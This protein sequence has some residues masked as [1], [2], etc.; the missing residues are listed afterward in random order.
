VSPDLRVTGETL[1]GRYWLE[2]ELGRG[3]TATVYLA[4]DLKHKRRVAL[5]ILNP[6][7]AA[8]V[9][10]R[11]LREIEIVAQLNHPNVLALYDSGQSDSLL[12]YVMPFVEGESLRDQ[13]VRRGRLPVAEAL[14]LT[15]EIADGLR[16][17]HRLG[18]VHR[19]IKPENILL[20]EGHAVIADFGIA[21]ALSVAGGDRLTESG[22]GV[23]TPAYMSPEQARGQGEVTPRSDVYSLGCV[24]YEMLAGEPPFSGPSPETVLAQKSAGRVPSLRRISGVFPQAIDDTLNRALASDPGERFESAPEFAEALSRA[25]DRRMVA[26]RRWRGWAAVA[27]VVGAAVIVA[28]GV[29]RDGNATGGKPPPGLS[30][31]GAKVG[32]LP[33]EFLGTPVDSADRQG[34]IVQ[35]LLAAELT[36]FRGLAVIDPLS[37][38]SRFQGPAQPSDP[39]L[40]VRD[41]GLEYVVRIT[42]TP[43]APGVRVSYALT[44]TRQG[45]VISAG[46]F[47]ATGEPDLTNRIRSA[48]ESLYA[49]LD[50]V[51]G[52]LSK[53]VDLDPFLART[54]KADAV[55]AFL[56][57][58][59]YSYRAIPGGRAHFERA[60]QLDPD[61][62]APRVWLVS[63][64]IEAGD[65]AGAGQHLRELHARA[66]GAT[67][68]EQALIGWA[69]G[70]VRGDLEATVRHLQV[71]LGYSP[72]NN[73]LLYSL[74]YSLFELGRSR[75]A[76]APVREAME[77]GWRYSRL[78]TLWGVVAIETGQTDSLYPLLVEARKITPADPYLSGLL[79]AL[80][81]YRGDTLAAVRHL[82]SFREDLGPPDSELLAQ[83]L[84][85]MARIY[86]ALARKA[87][88]ERQPEH[89][90]LLLERAVEVAPGSPELRLEL[91]RALIEAGQPAKAEQI[92]S[93]VAGDTS[94]SSAT[95]VFL[96]GEVATLLKRDDEARRSFERYLERWPDGAEV[97]TVRARLQSMEGRHGVP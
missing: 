38:N 23:G 15:R 55:N 41:L 73:I 24:F 59:E 21:H 92:Y 56:M 82:A 72:R 60:I 69:E 37:L 34:A 16:Y 3:G 33:P 11:F 48:A 61:F 28:R 68:F 20:S 67:P 52:G 64:F 29:D 43:Q 13:L 91:A 40:A 9:P 42:L 35:Y 1:A 77:S 58:A 80:A 46:S 32:V 27:A 54:P 26:G 70:K 25:W 2:R 74:A 94:A 85:E 4:T 36:R 5:K 31:T 62:I 90:V 71:A 6:H 47:S 7:L 39:L 66:K 83:K 97:A 78:Y 18:I 76:V 63:G 93:S 22:F 12:Y 65:T 8:I 84:A 89:A 45:E 96:L 44:S 14:R 49:A 87:R 57:G 10:D 19:D 50:R 51:S 30:S 86:L 79:E 88:T 75:D 95:V 53:S 81:L 17:A